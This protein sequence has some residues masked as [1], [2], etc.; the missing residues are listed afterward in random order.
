[1]L[2]GT[3]RNDSVFYYLAVKYIPVSRESCFDAN[4]LDGSLLEMVLE[5]NYHRNK[6]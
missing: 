3:S 1:M 6:K 2:A 5:K 4:R